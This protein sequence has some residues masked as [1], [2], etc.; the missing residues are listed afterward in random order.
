MLVT[1]DRA[2]RIVI[3]KSLR[4][5]LGIGPDTE[6]ELIPDGAGLRLELVRRRAREVEERDGL[7]LLGLVNGIVLTD[8]DVR[9]LRDDVQR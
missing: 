7:P 9:R 1:V 6:L 5:S 2:G 8:E 3:P 4:R